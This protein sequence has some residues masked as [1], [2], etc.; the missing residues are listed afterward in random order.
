[1]CLLGSRSIIN[2]MV[3]VAI[4][5]NLLYHILVSKLKKK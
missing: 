4:D 5:I 2:D 3:Y 1:M